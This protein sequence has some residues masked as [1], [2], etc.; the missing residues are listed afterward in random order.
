MSTRPRRLPSG[1]WKD[2]IGHAFRLIDEV[3]KHGVEDPF[4]TL[5]GGV[6]TADFVKLIRAEGEI[7]FVA[8]ANL[9]DAPFETWSLLRRRVRVETAVE[10]VAKK[11]WYRPAEC[12]RPLRPVA[13]HRAGVEAVASSLAVSREAPVSLHRPTGRAR[14]CAEGAVRRDRRDAVHTK[15]RGRCG[16]CR[17]LPSGIA[18]SAVKRLPAT[19][20]AGVRPIRRRSPGR[21][22]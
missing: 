8:A 9:T 3:A 22:D 11:L 12:A 19:D 18:R 15:L 6:E 20:G 16:A 10:I 14:G 13:R 2:L 5:G 7:D 1:P 21:W 4:W 17:G